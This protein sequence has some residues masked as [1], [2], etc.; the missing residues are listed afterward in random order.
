MKFDSN[1][2]ILLDHFDKI[3]YSACFI[4]LLICRLVSKALVKLC[5]L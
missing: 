4:F 3:K 1:F 5:Y 2:K